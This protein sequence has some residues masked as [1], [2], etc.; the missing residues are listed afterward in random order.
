[1]L[2]GIVW[3]RAD[4]CIKMDLALNNLKRLIYHKIQ[5]TNQRL[6]LQ[7]IAI[8]IDITSGSVHT[9]LYDIL[10]MNKLSIRVSL[11]NSDARA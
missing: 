6:T 7:N 3:N 9:I 4:F 1:M 2:N 5:P 8:I 10:W 11:K